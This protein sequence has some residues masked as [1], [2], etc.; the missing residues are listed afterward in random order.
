MN[1]VYSRTRLSDMLHHHISP[2]DSSFLLHLM[3][4][5]CFTHTQSVCIC[6]C[7]G[8]TGEGTAGSVI[9]CSRIAM[10]C[11]LR[12]WVNERKMKRRKGAGKQNEGLLS[13]ITDTK[14]HAYTCSMD[15]SYVF[16]CS[17]RL[18]GVKS[19]RDERLVNVLFSSCANS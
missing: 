8:R 7:R 15:P 16:S 18:L 12:K 13:Y 9:S 14:L 6:V 17:L 5:V 2:L 4:A 1:T 3:F 19:S 10:S 11:Y